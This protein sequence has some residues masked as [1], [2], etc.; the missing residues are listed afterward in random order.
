[1]P[2]SEKYKGFIVFIV[3]A[4]LCFF[5][6]NN[7]ILEEFSSRINYMRFNWRLISLLGIADLLYL[8]DLS[9]LTV[10]FYRLYLVRIKTDS[11]YKNIYLQFSGVFLS[12]AIASLMR[13]I[14]IFRMYM[15]IYAIFW[16]IS[17]IY[18]TM[19]M[20]EFLI[21]YKDLKEPMTPDYR[22]KVIKEMDERHERLKKLFNDNIDK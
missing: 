21:S 15:W 1:M 10:L 11:L 14:G 12:M 4:L 18:L 8:V 22:D 7:D 5:L 19:V 3:I 17:G 16:V 13:L 6:S 20:I 9:V 2:V